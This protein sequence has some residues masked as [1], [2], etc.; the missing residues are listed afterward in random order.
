MPQSWLIFLLFMSNQLD[1][2]VASKKKKAVCVSTGGRKALQTEGISM[3][4]EGSG[5]ERDWLLTGLP[6]KKKKKKWPSQS[7][8]SGR[9]TNV[10]KETQQW[11]PRCQLQWKPP[12]NSVFSMDRC[13]C[14]LLHVHTS[15]AQ[16][17][18]GSGIVTFEQ[19]G[20]C[21]QS[22]WTGTQPFT[23]MPSFQ[24]SARSSVELRM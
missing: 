11:S 14:R 1:Y 9:I 4:M 7:S 6:I 5:W 24:V 2:Y 10:N 22:P 15:S 13:R 17:R 23:E 16:F 21:P 19:Q 12:A 3:R 8:L 18:K 20:T